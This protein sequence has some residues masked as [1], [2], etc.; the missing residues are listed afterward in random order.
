VSKE[1]TQHELFM[2]AAIEQANIAEEHGEVPVGAVLVIDDLIVASGFNQSI[3]LNDPTAHA[4]IQCIRSA[5]NS[6]GNYRLP[7]AS[8]YTTLE[9]CPMCAGALVHSR[10][11]C[12]IY[13]ATDYR[14]GAVDTHLHIGNQNYA[15]EQKC[16]N[17][18]FDVIS[19]VLRDDCSELLTSFFRKRR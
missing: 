11:N 12:L 4:E 18:Q 17:H 15:I 8:L 2:R 5:C 3:S 13:G 19:D 1:Q 16:T 7:N 6:L 9:P 14:F 10:I